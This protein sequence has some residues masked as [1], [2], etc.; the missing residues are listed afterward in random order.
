MLNEEL[1]ILYATK[2]LIIFK[3]FTV[4]YFGIIKENALNQVEVS[5]KELRIN[6]L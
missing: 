3:K 4:L 6:Y 2:D 1:E 5:S